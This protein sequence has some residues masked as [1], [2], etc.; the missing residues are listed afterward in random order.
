MPTGFDSFS[1]KASANYTGLPKQEIANREL[2]KAVMAAHGF[3][4]IPTEWWHYD[5]NGWAG[6][7]LLDIP[8]SEIK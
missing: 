2:L 5:F 4:V 3:H 7:P 1:K 6:Y 8:F